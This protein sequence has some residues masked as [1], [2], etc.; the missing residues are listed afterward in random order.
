MKYDF[1]TFWC[2]KN[3]RLFS[4]NGPAPRNEPVSRNE[5]VSRN[6]SVPRNGPVPRNFTVR[7]IITVIVKCFFITIF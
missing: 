2:D 7:Y 3:F 6:G 1:T 4:V 5:A